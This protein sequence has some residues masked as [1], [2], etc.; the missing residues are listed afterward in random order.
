[1]TAAAAGTQEDQ[2]QGQGQA[3]AGSAA[4][5]AADARMDRI[6]A[7]QAQQGALLERI[8]AAVGNGSG[9]TP[10]AGGQQ[11]AAPQSLAEQVRREI[12]DADQRRRAEEDDATWRAGVNEVVE[13]VKAEG[14]PRD[15]E[16][17]FR[18]RAQRLLFGKPDA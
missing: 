4:P 9:G 8:A 3:A 2:G 11:P 17:G 16:T 18:G 1:M 14:Q 5:P 12:R 13:K 10:P 6:E 15:P 7:T